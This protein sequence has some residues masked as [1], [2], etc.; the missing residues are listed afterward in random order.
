MQYSLILLAVAV[1]IEAN[2]V[3]VPQ[4]VSAAISPS[5]PA[6]PGCTAGTSGT[7]GIAVYNATRPEV[8]KRQNNGINMK[9]EKS[10][11]EIKE[12]VAVRVLFL[13]VC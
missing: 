3:A 4:A 10:A 8:A 7:F 11:G 9:R 2:P 6:P 5:A 1:A 12:Y 13:P